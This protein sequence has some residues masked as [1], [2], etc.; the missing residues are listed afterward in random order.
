RFQQ[1][2]HNDGFVFLLGVENLDE[3]LIWLGLR[4]GA[5]R[6]WHASSVR[7]PVNRLRQSL[8]LCLAVYAQGQLAS[9]AEAGTMAAG[10]QR[11]GLGEHPNPKRTGAV[12]KCNGPNNQAE[13][14]VNAWK[15]PEDY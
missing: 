9:G 4:R 3:L 10:A 12:W 13:N 8:C 7:L 6:L 2:L 1:T 11:E 5:S 14:T 15:R